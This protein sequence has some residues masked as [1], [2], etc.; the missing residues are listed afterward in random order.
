[1]ASERNDDDRINRLNEEIRNLA[2]RIERQE[3]PKA[4]ENTWW[5]RAS[6]TV[7]VFLLAVSLTLGVRHEVQLSPV[8]HLNPP[9][10]VQQIEQPQKAATK[11][12]EADARRLEQWLQS[13]GDQ[14]SVVELT[15][16][17]AKDLKTIIKFPCAEAAEDEAVEILLQ[18]QLDASQKVSN[19]QQITSTERRLQRLVSLLKS[20]CM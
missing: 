14:E 7:G 18:L 15:S 13:P 1:M 17:I 2:Y 20:L 12:L 8:D 3:I 4:R 16:A 5:D 9:A 19:N 11:Q 10:V 6:R